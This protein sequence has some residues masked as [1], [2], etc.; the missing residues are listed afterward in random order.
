MGDKSTPGGSA[1]GS[2]ATVQE[3]IGRLKTVLEPALNR[4]A[5]ELLRLDSAHCAG[6]ISAESVTARTALPGFDNSQMDG[7]AVRSSDLKDLPAGALPLAGTVPAGSAAPELPEGECLAVMTGAPV[8][9]GADAVVPVEKTAE[10]FAVLR[11][12][13]LGEPVEVQFTGLTPQDLL[14]GRFIRAAGSDVAAGQTVLSPGERLTPARLGLLAACGTTELRVQERIRTL[15]LAT[16]EEICSPGE[17]LA[18]GQLYDANSGLIR[19][20]CEGFGHTVYAAR[21]PGDKPE[22]FDAALK[23]LTAQHRPHL[24]IT[25]G[26]IS[27]GA[28]EVVRQALAE[29]GVQ[30]GSVAQQPGGPQGWGMLD[31]AALIALPGNPVSCSV[32]LEALLRPALAELDS[33]CPPQRRVTVTVGEMMDSPPGIRQFRRV[34]LRGEK[35]LPVGGPSSHLLGHLARADALLEIPEG[36]TEVPKGT[37]LEAILL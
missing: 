8:P 11:A 16:G 25:A 3:H 35:A 32:S 29:R 36:Q 12:L 22:E 23:E 18:P 30:F 7:F 15:V 17:L 20:A 31:Q 27:A 19:A 37:V 6:R 33:A 34:E 2:R 10:G 21:I 28:Y 13:D 5:T 9:A 1:G 26:G 24:I 14:P 4:R